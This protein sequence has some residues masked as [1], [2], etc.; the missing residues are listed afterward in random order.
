MRRSN[1]EP[2]RI[3]PNGGRWRRKQ[4]IVLRLLR[5]EPIAALSGELG[6]VQK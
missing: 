4:E 1:G 2:G 3:F 6:V 5:G